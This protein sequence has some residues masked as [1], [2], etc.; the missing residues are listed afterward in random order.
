MRLVP[1]SS[2]IACAVMRKRILYRRDAFL[3]REIVKFSFRWRA[4]FRN[5]T[6]DE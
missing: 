4:A 1:V 6:I 5:H 3:S 2:D